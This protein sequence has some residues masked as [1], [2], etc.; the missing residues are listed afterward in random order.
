M[1]FLKITSYIDGK[2]NFMFLITLTIA[3]TMMISTG[4]ILSHLFNECL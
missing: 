1:D 3:F 2:E 4:M